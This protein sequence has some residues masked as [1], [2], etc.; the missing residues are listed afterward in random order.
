MGRPMP[1]RFW[2]LAALCP[3]LVDADVIGFSLGIEY[4]AFF[5]HRGF[6]HS[7]MFAAIFAAVVVA[8]EFRDR[9]PFSRAWWGMFAFF[10]LIIG[11]HGVL[12]ALTDGGLGIA[13]LSP[14]DTTRYFFPW[15]P[16]LVSP[17]GIVDFFTEY[18]LQAVLSEVKWVWLPLA[19]LTL[20]A[21][22]A[23]HIKAVCLRARRPPDSSAR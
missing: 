18:G 8:V 15:T 20:S 13:I 6:F 2:A 14:F 16:I 19:V 22:V 9:R 5:G 1:W 11:S 7:L 3:A 4:E 23:D 12:D 21:G 10:F 17:I